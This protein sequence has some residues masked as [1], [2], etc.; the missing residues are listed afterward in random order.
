MNQN[1]TS[2]KT[3]DVV[4]N[5]PKGFFENAGNKGVLITFLLISLV[6]FF[7]FKDFILLKKLYLYKD[8]GSDTVNGVWPYFYHYAYYLDKNGLPTWSFGEGMGQNILGGLLRDPFMLIGYLAGPASMPKIYI[9]IELTKIITG[10]L[11]FHLFLKQ[12]KVSNFSATIGSL[13]FSFSGFMV[14]GSCWYVFTYEALTLVLML[15]GFEL[16]FQK[17]KWLVFVLSIFLIAISMPFN[18]YVSGLFLLFYILFRLGQTNQLN[19]KNLGQLLLKLIVFGFIGLLISAPFLLETSLQLLESPRGSGETS[20]F[21]QLAS[22]SVLALIDRLQ[23][24]TFINRLYSSDLLGSGNNFKAWQNFLEAPVSYCGLISIILMP[25]IFPFVSKPA[26]KWYIIWLAIW[27]VS[28]IFPYFR[29]LFWLFTGDYYR[30]FSFCLLLVFILYSVL[31]L[32]LILKH[33]KINLIALGISVL[34]SLILLGIDYFKGTQVMVDET[35]SIFVK[36]WLIIY[37]ILLFFI[38][39]P[40]SGNNL[41]YLLLLIVCV[42]LIFLSSFSVNRRDAMYTREL[43]EKIAY[44]DYSV[45]AVDYIKKAEKGFYRIDKNYYSSGAIHG[46]LNDHKIHNYYST[47]CYSSFSNNNYINYLRSFGVI[48]KEN[49]FESRWA[50]GLL[51]RPILQSLNNVKY[52]LAKGYSNPVWRSSHDSVAKFG[53]VLVLKS[54]YSLPF[55]YTYNSYITQSDFDKLGNNQKDFVCLKACVIKDETSANNLQGLK[56]FN[57]S[58]TISAN[59]FTFDRYHSEITSLGKESLNTTL[60]SEK[61]IE[62]N[63]VTSEP[64][65]MYLSFPLDK[66]WH[67]KLNNTDAELITINNGMTGVYLPKGNNT[68]EMTYKLR[69]FNIGLV[70]IPF[71]LLLLIILIILDK[72]GKNVLS[73]KFINN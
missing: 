11:I 52:I 60:F 53:D 62:G 73:Y 65:M 58:D 34:G 19:I 54:K 7:I 39:K 27:V 2:K 42:E 43:T 31:A 57:L 30:I 69:V 71:G 37:S 49:E 25:Q 18:L 1:K 59:Q 12:L 51:N 33:K 23:F 10:G 32:D 56:K 20:Y 29:H 36:T 21:N 63:I 14:I 17:N 26:R 68:L 47:S 15:L 38:A 3:V 41:K 48:S 6:A 72:K 40:S 35:I 5:T 24:G 70:V 22:K 9:Y 45:D 44:N 55:G 8:I 67:L 66:G 64:K 61:R 4:L 46:S 28:T 50:P 16:Y 13:V